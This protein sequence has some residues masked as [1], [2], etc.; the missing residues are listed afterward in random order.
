MYSKKIASIIPVKNRKHLVIEAINSVITQDYPVDEIIVIDDGSTDGTFYEIKRHF[1]SLPGLKIIK[2]E[3]LGPGRARN[4]GVRLSSVDVVMF[5]DS[6]DIWLKNHVHL[7]LNE[8][9]KGADASFGI[10]ENISLKNK[11]K[12]YIPG[13]EFDHQKPLFE[14]ILSWCS[15]V[16]SSF[17]IKKQIFL[18]LNGFE[19]IRFG[20]DW[21]FFIKAAKKIDISFVDKVITIRRLH[22]GNICQK[23][24]SIKKALDLLHKIL[25]I[26][27]KFY[28]EKQLQTIKRNIKI[29]KELEGRCQSV[30]EWY[31]TLTQ[32][33]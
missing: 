23:E 14:N 27:G 6:D 28:T 29:T 3:N 16:P 18:S 31:L 12:F 30:Q 17:A 26:A 24:F 9:K 5:L 13:P 25:T 11:D 33:I 32:K 22:G 4:L 1:S 8:I 19:Q 20:E 10:T 21:C 7:L 15:I 2:T